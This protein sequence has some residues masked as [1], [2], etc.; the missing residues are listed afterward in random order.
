LNESKGVTTR[1]AKTKEENFLPGLEPPTVIATSFLCECRDGKRRAVTTR[2]LILIGLIRP[3]GRIGGVSRLLLLLPTTTYRSHDFLEAARRLNVDVTVASEE[4]SAVEG[5]NPAGLLTMDFRDPEGCVRQALGF[6]RTNPI[7]AVVGVDED[8]AVAAAAI[9]GALRLPANPPEAV[10][11]ARNKGVLR[12][13]LDAAGVPTPRSR[14]FRREEGPEEA[15]EISPYPC[16]LKPTFLAASRGVIRAD[17]PAS[18]RLAWDRIAAILAQP[19]VA[20]KGG[21]A[22][23]EILVEEFVPGSEVAVEGLLFQGGLEVLAVFDKPDPLDGP[24]FEE[25][26]YVTPSRLAAPALDAVRSATERASRA[27]GLRHGPI[28]AE[29]RI[30]PPGPTVIE[31]A[32]R[33]IGG[34]CSR[35]LQFGTGMSLEELILRHALSREG[36]SPPRDS[37]AAG[38]MM[39]PIPRGGRLERV[40]GVDEARRVSDV[41]DVVISA[42]PGQVLVPLPEGSRYLGF[43]FSRAGTAERAEA[44]LREAHAKLTFEIVD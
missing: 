7:D 42:R 22:A 23:N 44:A 43:L 26:I 35:T 30:G 21:D 13:R 15:S 28:H 4:P 27:L 12:R 16:V 38:V 9:S 11:A 19:E 25:T 39:I 37:R 3:P 5:L 32:A 2:Q 20:A 18:F 29:I 17:D 10:A 1:A 41:E 14:L 40:S 33:S 24:F 36:D 6:S 31:V 8:T 34:L